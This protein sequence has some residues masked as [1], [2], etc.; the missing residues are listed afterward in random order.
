MSPPTTPET[1]T[2]PSTATSLSDDLELIDSSYLNTIEDPVADLL[3]RSIGDMTDEE[4]KIML[5]ELASLNQKPG[6]LQRRLSEEA[7]VIKTGAK[8][9]SSKKSTIKASQFI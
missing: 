2:T 6:E 3:V 7:V 5:E 1:P 4:I 9:T 8:R